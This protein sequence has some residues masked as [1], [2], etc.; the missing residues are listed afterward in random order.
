MNFNKKSLCGIL[1]SILVAFSSTATIA[2]VDVT[3]YPLGMSPKALHDNLVNDKFVFKKFSSTE[4]RAVK[5]VAVE[6][7]EGSEFPEITQSTSLIAKICAGK[8]YQIKMNSIY[9]GDRTSLLMG[10]KMLYKYLKDN[11]ATND[12]INLHKNKSDPTVVLGF[13]IDRNSQTNKAVRG[14]EIVKLALGTRK[15]VVSARTKLP[16]LQMSYLLENKWFCPN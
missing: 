6:A 5:K 16:F 4:I 12:G 2:D 3:K 8:V 15:D 7:K 10:R 1:L 11:S 14:T 9:G 13:S